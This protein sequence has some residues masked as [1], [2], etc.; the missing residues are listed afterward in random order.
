MIIEVNTHVGF[1]VL[2]FV[3]KDI[4]ESIVKLLIRYIDQALVLY[5]C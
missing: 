4:L 2:F 1:S 5:Q 3:T